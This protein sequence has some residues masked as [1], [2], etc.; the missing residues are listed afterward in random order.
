VPLGPGFGHETRQISVSVAAAD[1]RQ[2]HVHVTDVLKND[3]NR[4]L[5]YLDADLPPSTA[6]GHAAFHADGVELHAAQSEFTGAWRVA[7]NSPW[8]FG[9]RQRVIVDYDLPPLSSSRGILGATPDSLFVADDAAFPSWLT[10]VGIFSTGARHARTESIEVNVPADFRV[11]APGREQRPVRNG[12]LSLHKFVQRKWDQR[13][14]VVA[15]RY[16]ESRIKTHRGEMIFWTFRALDARQAQ[17]AAE[18]LAES[19]ATYRKLFGPTAERAW[20]V[21]IVEAHNTPPQGEAADGDVSAA[22]FPQGVIL[23]ERAMQQGIDAEPVLERAEYELARIWFGWHVRSAPDSQ[24]LLGGGLSW[25]AVTRA[26]LARGGAAA[27]KDEVDRLLAD[28]DDARKRGEDGALLKLPADATDER[29]ATYVYRAA[30]FVVEL[31]DLAG[32]E[33]FDSALR[34]VLNAG[35]IGDI[36]ADELRSALEAATGKDLSATFRAWLNGP[37]VPGDFR[38]RYTE[39]RSSELR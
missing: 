8:E 37:G 19:A 35:R 4:N 14:F 27:R 26:A 36:D 12:P 22:S 32:R 16:Q 7:F 29:R 33:H 25:Y 10:P 24:V 3:G 15:G 31:E 11:L 20:T 1:S 28:Y 38:S 18:R 5:P 30:L 34:R 23:D 13:A 21:H 17:A 9:S 2:V 6:A 39:V